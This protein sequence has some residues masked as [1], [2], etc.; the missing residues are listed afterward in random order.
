MPAVN[1]FL[2]VAQPQIVAAR[3]QLLLRLEIL[4]GTYTV[5][6]SVTGLTNVSFTATA[7]DTTAPTIGSSVSA[8]TTSTGATIIWTTDELASSIVDYGLTTPTEALPQKRILPTRVTS[9]SVSLKFGCLVTT[10]PYRVRSK[11]ASA[12]QGT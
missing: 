4:A 8:S 11:D 6:A 2:R 9:H 12:N 5:T 7:T 3:L 10:Y 1:R